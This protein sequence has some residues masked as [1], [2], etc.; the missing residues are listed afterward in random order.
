MNS[1]SGDP[2]RLSSARRMIIC[3][4]DTDSNDGM[5][6]TYLAALLADELTDAGLG[7]VEGFPH[8]IR[9]NP[10]IPYKT[11][12]NAAL[13]FIFRMNDPS[14]RESGSG[15]VIISPASADSYDASFRKIREHVCSRI[16]SFS[17]TDC[18]KT[19]P[20]AVFI[21]DFLFGNVREPLRAHF[22]KALTDVVSVEDAFSLAGSLGIPYF[23][24]KCG[25]GLIGALAAAG[26]LLSLNDSGI[27]DF[28][29]TF[30]YLAYRRRDAWGT[31]RHVSKESLFRADA[32]TYPDTWDTV[33]LTGKPK[34]LVVC[35]PGSPD[36]VLYGIR[37]RSPEDVGKAASFIESEPVE[38]FRIFLTN[39]GT[40]AHLIPVSRIS[41]MRPFHSY[42]I[43][44]TVCRPPEMIEG[45]H[46]IFSISDD[47]GSEIA[48]AAYEPTGNFRKIVRQ[49][50][51]GDLVTVSGSLKEN[52]EKNGRLT[53]NIEKLTIAETVPEIVRENPSCPVCGR[54]T[55]S[56]GAGQ[57]FRCRRCRTH[58]GTKTEKVIDRSFLCGRYEVP[59]S[60]RRH[61]S[62]PLIRDLSGS[63]SDTAG[64]A[65]DVPSYPSRRF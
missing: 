27:P 11:R 22:R 4:D 28:D 62:K 38:R 51:T 64:S 39:Q 24:L 10:T 44:G 12:G 57:G 58:A 21:P 53:L 40:D 5:C 14:D 36:P 49:L 31:K 32:E 48:C 42:R 17:M 19:N 45:G 33:D 25:R 35:V 18:E 56:A 23:Y 54:K 55:E 7:C 43:S 37:G 47:S 13:G 20:G 3:L 16:S 30:E 65:E 52:D 63:E 59:P 8:L 1:E 50:R 15:P 46:A 61:L 6:T 9:L 26:S 41:E 2:E 34:P 29:H 60:A